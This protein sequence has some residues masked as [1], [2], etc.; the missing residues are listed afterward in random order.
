MLVLALGSGDYGMARPVAHELLR[1]DVLGLH[2]RHLPSIVEVGV[3][4]GDRGL[5]TTALRVLLARASASGTP[6]ALGVLARS[7]ALLAG[8]GDAE[9]LYRRAVALLS[10][11]G[12]EADLA[13]AHLLYGEWLRRRR[14]R[15]DARAPLRTSLAMFHAMRADAFATRAARELAATGEHVSPASAGARDQLTAQ[16]REIARLAAEGATNAEIASR[17]TIS[18]NTVDYHL[19]KVFRKL[20]VPSRRRL[21]QALRG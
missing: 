2:S 7:Q 21:A 9:P 8:A 4:C 14:R 10:R 5:A 3:R 17:M 16:E 11:T 18:A 13:I 20:D 15:K 12:A 19:R 6:W 1:Q